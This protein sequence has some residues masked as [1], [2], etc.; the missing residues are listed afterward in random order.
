MG[1]DQRDCT[2]GLQPS[3]WVFL[4][5][6]T[7]GTAVQRA[8]H[9]DFHVGTLVSKSYVTR[10]VAAPLSPISFA[11]SEVGHSAAPALPGSTP[12]A[13]RPAFSLHTRDN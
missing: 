13:D 7:F 11:G 6:P 9:T 5:A 4:Q 2:G 3:R 1:G 10:P 8:Q 12:A